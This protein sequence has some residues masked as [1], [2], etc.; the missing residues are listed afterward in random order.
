[1]TAVYVNQSFQ[2]CCP[3]SS[4]GTPAGVNNSARRVVTALLTRSFEQR[5]HSI[6]RPHDKRRG[7]PDALTPCHPGND[8]HTGRL[9]HLIVII[10]VEKLA[11]FVVTH[12][13]VWANLVCLR[14]GA[15]RR[16]GESV[17]SASRPRDQ[18]SAA[19]T[20]RMTRNTLLVDYH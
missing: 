17:S 13:V 1:M 3:S 2:L 7:R 19:V 16:Q 20:T 12:T 9:A 5:C 14:D 15:Y 4:I 11:N 6:G 18:H 8:A 10:Q